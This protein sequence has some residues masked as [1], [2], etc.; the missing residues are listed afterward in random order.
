MPTLPIEYLAYVYTATDPFT[1]YY[2]FYTV[3]ALRKNEAHAYGQHWQHAN[4]GNS[5]SKAPE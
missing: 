5:Q 3:V 2:F 1:L 4:E